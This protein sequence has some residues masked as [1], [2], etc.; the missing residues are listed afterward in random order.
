MAGQV[1]VSVQCVR[2]LEPS[3][4]LV[5]VRL[6]DRSSVEL[7][8]C[9]GCRRGWAVTRE[10]SGLRC[11]QSASKDPTLWFL[12]SKHGWLTGTDRALEWL[13]D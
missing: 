12:V 1:P 9:V 4:M 8:Q 10:V 2:K 3:A 6:N 13:F 5:K 11:D 7:F